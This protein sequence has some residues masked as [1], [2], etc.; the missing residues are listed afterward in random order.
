MY[1]TVLFLLA[2][3]IQSNCFSQVEFAPAGAEWHYRS[4]FGWMGD[5]VTHVQSIKDTIVAGKD[6]RKLVIRSVA[7]NA[8]F[9]NDYIIHQSA[10]SVFGVREW[11]GIHSFDYLF[12]T[13]MEIGEKDKLPNLSG[14]KEFEVIA[15]DTLFFNNLPV[16]RYKL[17][18]PTSGF[19][20][21]IYDR[22][23]PEYGFW[24]Y[25]LSSPLDGNDHYL[26]CYQDD[27]FDQVNVSN[28]ECD[29]GFPTA[30]NES[31][32][33]FL[34]TFPNPVTDKLNISFPQN[35]MGTH[36][37]SIFH[38]SGKKIMFNLLDGKADLSYL[39]VGFYVGQI[40]IKE[41][42][43]YLKFIKQ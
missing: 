24:E 15:L 4:L 35:L 32:K 29:D 19:E 27:N 20:T 30:I 9:M 16:K 5:G 3:F 26:R 33:L 17:I 11:E 40:K 13:A 42:V 23:G 21:F 12:S 41:E 18:E 6:C 31:S 2:F 14:D 36:S 39:P 1:K 38:V 37:L 10:D 34:K 43:Y 28:E 25:W 7:T 22:F 8:D